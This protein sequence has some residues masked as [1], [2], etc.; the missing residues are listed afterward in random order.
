MPRRVEAGLQFREDTA[1]AHALDALALV[2][3][4]DISA[5][6]GEGHGVELAGEHHIGV[7]NKLARDGVLVGR[8]ADAELRSSPTR[9][10]ASGAW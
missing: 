4:G 6:E 1:V 10:P 8:D 7:V 9:P 3:L 5:D 2:A